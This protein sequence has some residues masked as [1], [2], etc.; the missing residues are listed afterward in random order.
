MP[1][2]VTKK[3]TID[4]IRTV[5]RTGNHLKLILSGINAIGFNM[6]ERRTSLRPGDTIDVAYTID[7]DKF[8]GPGKVQIKI[9]DISKNES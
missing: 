5:G 6:G 4:D 1:V 7:E 3:M 2:F 8:N 9:K